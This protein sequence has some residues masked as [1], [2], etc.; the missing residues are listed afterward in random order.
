MKIVSII[1]HKGGVGKTTFTGSVAQALALVGFRVLAID[2]DSQHNLSTMLGVG[3][4]SPSIRIMRLPGQAGALLK[5]TLGIT[6][7]Q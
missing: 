1:I 7:K 2:N 5:R 6:R 4:Q 3:V